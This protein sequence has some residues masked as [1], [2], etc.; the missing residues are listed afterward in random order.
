M[1][2]QAAHLMRQVMQEVIFDL[3]RGTLD[4][5]VLKHT[6]H[7]WTD[8][9]AKDL[10]LRHTVDYNA[11]EARSVLISTLVTPLGHDMTRLANDLF[12]HIKIVSGYYG[13]LGRFFDVTIAYCGSVPAALVDDFTL[14]LRWI[15]IDGPL[16]PPDPP[17]K[18]EGA[19]KPRAPFYWDEEEELLD[20]GIVKINTTDFPKRR[21][22]QQQRFTGVELLRGDAKI[23]AD[24]LADRKYQEHVHNTMPEMGPILCCLHSWWNQFNVADLIT[25]NNC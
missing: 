18:I 9:D 23:L 3:E 13:I 4:H 6:I 11:P 8:N 20:I 17:I 12:E 19:P 15:H 25:I 1:Q 22:N 2:L 10:Y 14:R 7:L 5:K 16:C 24:E 21:R